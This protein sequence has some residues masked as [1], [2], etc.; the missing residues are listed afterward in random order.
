[1]KTDMDK[2]SSFQNGFDDLK[3][4][5]NLIVLKCYKLNFSIKGQTKNFFSYILIAFFIINIILI[6]I[7]E[8]YLN[9]NLDD[10]IKYCKEF[11]DNNNNNNEDFKSL[12]NIY[13][14]INKNEAIIESYDRF[15]KEKILSA[16]TKRNL[17]NNI[18]KPYNEKLI[19]NININ[20]KK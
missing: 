4:K 18:S 19:L 3:T 16:P 5:N 13:L 1:M 6:I 9:H 10:L 15:L 12:R 7:I 14:N 17:H 2:E 11:I 20:K 8:L